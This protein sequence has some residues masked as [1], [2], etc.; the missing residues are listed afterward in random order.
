[1]VSSD[2]PRL[3]H[4]GPLRA[5]RPEGMSD[6]PRPP[7]GPRGWRR[8]RRGRSSR[9]VR[10]PT[11]RGVHPEARVALTKRC[12]PNVGST[13]VDMRGILDRVRHAMAVLAADVLGAVDLL[14]AFQHADAIGE[15]GELPRRGLPARDRGGQPLEHSAL[16]VE[17]HRCVLRHQPSVF[18]AFLADQRATGPAVLVDD[19]AESIGVRHVDT[20][21]LHRP[22]PVEG[23][24]RRR[25]RRKRPPYALIFIRHPRQLGSELTVH[26]FQPR[27]A[28]PPSKPCV[29]KVF[30][31]SVTRRWP[32][33]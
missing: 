29:A 27:T 30:C 31:R 28:N 3:S 22:R 17:L 9:A 15:V 18:C 14:L 8:S 26:R 7:P 33:V 24:R 11:R 2:Q 12:K 6:R 20:S 23:R 32:E 5:L 4:P 10:P 13:L 19:L 16:E 21:H 25:V 1:V